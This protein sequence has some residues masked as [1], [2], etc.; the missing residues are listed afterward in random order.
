MSKLLD[1]YKKTKEKNLNNIYIF[2]I[3]IFY[4]ILNEDARIVSNTIELKLIA[5]SPKIIKCEFSI[6]KSDKYTNLLKT[7]NLKFEIISAS[8]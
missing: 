8:S 6:A 4:N 2:R 1:P 7:N 3:N 5:L